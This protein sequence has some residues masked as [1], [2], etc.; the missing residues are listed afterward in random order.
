LC[1]LTKCLII[2]I[3]IEPTEVIRIDKKAGLNLW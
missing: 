1:S 3:A 2:A